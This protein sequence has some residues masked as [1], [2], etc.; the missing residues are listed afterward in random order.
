LLP[1]AGA[2][3]IAR[4][5]HYLEIAPAKLQLKVICPTGTDSN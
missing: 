3:E 5:A 4:I 1:P 2:D